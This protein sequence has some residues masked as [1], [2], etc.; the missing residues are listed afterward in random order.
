MRCTVLH[1]IAKL[2]FVVVI[3]V[4]F[5]YLVQIRPGGQPLSRG[6]RVSLFLV[7]V[8]I[9]VICLSTDSMYEIQTSV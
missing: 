1:T 4:L 2:V 3:G 9:G 8:I 5:P 7:G 6:K